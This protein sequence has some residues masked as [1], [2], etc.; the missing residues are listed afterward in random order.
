M[1]KLD[2][3]LSYFHDKASDCIRAG[4]N[5][6]VI[7]H[8]DCDGIPSGSIVTKSLIRSGAK[9]TLKTVN[10]FS[11]NIIDK[12][13]NHSRHFHIITDLVGGFPKNLDNVLD[14][15]CIGVD[16]GQLPQEHIDNER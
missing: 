10:E 13:K 7:T 3:A 16:H 12:L 5:I 2:L 15:N 11:K 6:S 1:T 14:N 4:K 9:C 8:L